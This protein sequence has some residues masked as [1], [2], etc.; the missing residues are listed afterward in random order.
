MRSVHC[1]FSVRSHTVVVNHETIGF[2]WSLDAKNV[3]RKI[4]IKIDL[5]GPTKTHKS[6]SELN[7]QTAK[8]KHENNNNNNK[9]I[10]NNMFSVR[11]CAS[12]SVCDDSESNNNINMSIIT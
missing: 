12:R 11:V 7:E 10:W 9:I 3:N 1:M 5:T 4:T 2:K 6:N 8:L